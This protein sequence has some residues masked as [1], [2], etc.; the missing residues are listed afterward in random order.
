MKISATQLEGVFIFEPKVFGDARGSF[1]ESVNLRSYRN[2]LGDDAPTEIVQIN[3]SHSI[4][5]SLR[6]LHFQEPKGQ[7]KI[8]WV[9]AGLIFD[10]AVDVRRDSPSFGRWTGQELS[11][12]NRL[13]MWIPPGFAHG[14]CVLSETADFM[15]ACTGYYAPDCER[16]VRWNDPAIAIDWPVTD[17]LLSDKDA[18]APLL[19]DA[20]VLPE[21]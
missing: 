3:H 16:A 18:A 13:Q 12:A 5:G 15:Y 11:A 8:V 10:V 7:G 14:F 17:P 1:F 21:L 6:G 20:P 4:H 9:S 19:A 2:L